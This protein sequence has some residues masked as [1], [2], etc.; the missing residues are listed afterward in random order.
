MSNKYCITV[1][2][3]IYN[4]CYYLKLHNACQSV[5]KKGMRVS[6]PFS[7]KNYKPPCNFIRKGMKEQ[8]SLKPSQVLSVRT[9]RP[10]TILEPV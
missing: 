6:H 8:K 4:Q 7:K 9:K 3:S 1:E 10:K 5:W 2:L